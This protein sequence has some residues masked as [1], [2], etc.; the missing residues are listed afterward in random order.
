V[1]ADSGLGDTEPV[2]Y[3]GEAQALFEEGG[4][5][6]PGLAAGTKGFVARPRVDVT[7]SHRQLPRPVGNAEPPPGLLR[8]IPCLVVGA[9]RLPSRFRFADPGIEPEPDRHPQHSAPVD[10]QLPGDFTSGNTRCQQ[11]LD[12][13]VPLSHEPMF[14][15]ESDEKRL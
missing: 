2:R 4:N 7:A 3:L 6:S 13:I 12:P 10:A 14:A 1:V 8:V 5:P 11:P 15:C 9:N